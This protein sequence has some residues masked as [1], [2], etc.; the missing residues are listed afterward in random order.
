[1]SDFNEAMFKT[2]VDNIFIKIYTCI[3]KQDLS[4]VMHFIGESLEKELSN[5]INK[6]DDYNFNIYE[7]KSCIILCEFNSC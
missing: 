6:F 1:M 3:M 5:I 7:S 2:K 4:D